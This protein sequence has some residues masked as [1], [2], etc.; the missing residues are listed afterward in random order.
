M[1]IADDII[2]QIDNLSKTYESSGYTNLVLDKIK[3]EIN[4]NEIS[5][6]VGSNGCGKTTLLKI[7]ANHEIPDDDF[8]LYING[9]KRIKI[10]GKDIVYLPQNIDFALADT[11][12]ISEYLS[13]F[14]QEKISELLK[15]INLDWL[16]FYIN[17]ISQSKLIQE[18]SIGQKQILLGIALL[19]KNCDIYLFDEVFSAMDDENRKIYIQLLI[20]QVKN[21]NCCAIIVTHDVKFAALYADSVLILKNCHIS[22]LQKKDIT[23]NK[24]VS[25]LF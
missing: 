18:L 20:K 12:K 7:L 4:R 8:Y 2:L 1:V 21:N 9:E 16:N 22:K 17:N 25:N 15:I 3:F 24:L 6:L 13:L 19:S 23:F 5:F 14:D 10:N 11:L